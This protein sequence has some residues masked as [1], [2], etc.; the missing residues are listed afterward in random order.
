MLGAA[1]QNDDTRSKADDVLSTVSF[2]RRTHAGVHAPYGV[3]RESTDNAT[4][5]YPSNHQDPDS[6]FDIG[7]ESCGYN[8]VDNYAPFCY[9]NIILRVIH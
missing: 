6:Y 2:A 7:T 8:H 9:S 1:S 5:G 4:N 3:R